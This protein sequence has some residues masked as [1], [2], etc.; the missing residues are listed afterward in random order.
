MVNELSKPQS[1]SVDEVM[2]A[3]ACL[4]TMGC[5]KWKWTKHITIPEQ[6]DVLAEFSRLA[7]ERM[8]LDNFLTP[9]EQVHNWREKCVNRL[10][11]LAADLEPARYAGNFT[12]ELPLKNVTDKQLFFSFFRST[13]DRLM[14]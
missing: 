10:V 3:A 9:G 2:S 12:R 14:A 11:T 1:I 5:L 4:R 8:T 13:I 6:V 7:V